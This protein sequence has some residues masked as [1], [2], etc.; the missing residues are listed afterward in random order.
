MLYP[1]AGTRDGLDDA[2]TP[3]SEDESQDWLAKVDVIEDEKRI[4]SET[5][6]TTIMPEQVD[7]YRQCFPALYAVVSVAGH[8]AIVDSNVSG[9]ELL[10]EVEST[11]EVLLGSPPVPGI[12]QTPEPEPPPSSRKVDLKS[13]ALKTPGQE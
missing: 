11:L 6:A 12:G 9:K 5:F 3:P 4:L 13:D 1:S 7:I 8:S 2:V 10:D